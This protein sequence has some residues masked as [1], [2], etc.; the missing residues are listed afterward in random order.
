MPKLS[1]RTNPPA[2]SEDAFAFPFERDAMR[3]KRRVPK[4]TRVDDVERWLM[5]AFKIEVADGALILETSE[6]TKKT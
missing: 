4:P 2:T 6:S 1:T 3:A 5:E